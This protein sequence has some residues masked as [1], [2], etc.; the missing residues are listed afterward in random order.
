MRADPDDEFSEVVDDEAIGWAAQRARL[1]RELRELWRQSEAK[2]TC[3]AEEK[4]SAEVPGGAFHDQKADAGEAADSPSE[5]R[6]C[7][8]RSRNN[9]I[10]RVACEEFGLV[11]QPPVPPVAGRYCKPAPISSPNRE[12]AW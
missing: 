6:V 8:A 3:D 1:R 2:E 11:E 12:Y 7:S 10:D 9:E 5:P 4:I